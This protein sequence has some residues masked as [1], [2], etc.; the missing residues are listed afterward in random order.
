MIDVKYFIDE[1]KQL[2]N[3]SK[4]DP[5]L[6]DKW[7]YQFLN[8]L[9]NYPGGTIGDENKYRCLAGHLY[10]C[11]F[12]VYNINTKAGIGDMNRIKDVVHFRKSFCNSFGYRYSESEYHKFVNEPASVLEVLLL[13]AAEFSLMFVWSYGDEWRVHIINVMKMFF[14]HLEI[15]KWTDSEWSMDAMNH[16]NHHL[17]NFLFHKYEFNGKGG[18]FPLDNPIVDQRDTELYQQMLMF[19][20]EKF[21]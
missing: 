8:H 7:Y 21:G 9:M 6:I 4:I 16:V 13:I 12:F 2:Y 19:Y 18:I 20:T 11:P 17:N 10:N 3:V 14:C 1:F 15:D 5:D